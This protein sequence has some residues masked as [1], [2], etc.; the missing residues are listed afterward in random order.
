MVDNFVR[1]IQ[2]EAWSVKPVNMVG[3]VGGF[4]LNENILNKQVSRDYIYRL[5]AWAWAL[6]VYT[7]FNSN[8]TLTIFEFNSD[9]WQNL[10]DS[11]ILVVLTC[12]NCLKVIREFVNLEDFGNRTLRAELEGIGR[13]KM[14]IW[15]ILF[16]LRLLR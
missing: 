2:F 15:I 1:N 12:L 4:E 5:Y 14:T 13:I 16:F 10:N 9:K 11:S 8:L 7:I 3:L 6:E